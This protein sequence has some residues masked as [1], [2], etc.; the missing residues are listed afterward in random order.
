[1]QVIRRRLYGTSR[2]GRQPVKH[3]LLRSI[4]GTTSSKPLKMSR[5][6][7]NA[8][9]RDSRF[10]GIKLPDRPARRLGIELTS[11][12]MPA[13]AC[14]HVVPHPD[15]VLAWGRSVPGTC[16]RPVGDL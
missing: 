3:S 7:L 1:I 9:T 15:V 14:L 5:N 10:P 16:V 12:G 4:Q 13:S 11:R 2:D 6:F 8:F